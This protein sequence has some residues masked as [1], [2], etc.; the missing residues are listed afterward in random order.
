MAPM[1]DDVARE[2]AS[3]L[4]LKLSPNVIEAELLLGGEGTGF[5]SEIETPMAG[6]V[7]VRG[8]QW[9]GKVQHPYRRTRNT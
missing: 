4:R 8:D 7:G 2:L 3:H 6:E 1:M 5:S 9:R